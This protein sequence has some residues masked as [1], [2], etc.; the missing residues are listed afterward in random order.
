MLSETNASIVVRRQQTEVSGVEMEMRQRW[1]VV[2]VS[3][4][5]GSAEVELVRDGL[6]TYWTLFIARDRCLSSGVTGL[7]NSNIVAFETK[8][9]TWL[10]AAV[11]L[12]T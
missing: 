8:S 9:S 3:V 12:N 6:W 4:L 11:G 10:Y 2:V 7:F 5:T 1:G